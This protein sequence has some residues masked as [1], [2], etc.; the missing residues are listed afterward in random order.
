[1]LSVVLR[2]GGGIF[3]IF[4]ICR[5]DWKFVAVASVFLEGRFDLV[6]GG[7]TLWGKV[8]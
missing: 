5:W 2:E 1:M 4:I 6:D 8:E 3:G 7:G